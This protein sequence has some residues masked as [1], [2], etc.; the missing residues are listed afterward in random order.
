[1]SHAALLRVEAL[2]KRFGAL[3]V[4]D[5]ISLQLLPGEIH[6][7]IGP[8]GAGKSTLVAQISGQ[9]APDSGSIWLGEHNVTHW[10]VQRRAQQ[11]LGRTFQISSVFRSLSELDNVQVAFNA[12]RR[13]GSLWRR[14]GLQDSLGA[15]SAVLERLQVRPE[16]RAA[17]ALGYG[18][19]RQLELAMGLVQQPSVL[20]LDEPLAGL[21]AAE[22]Q[23]VVQ[24]L[25]ALRGKVAMLLIEHDMDAV[26]ALADRISVLV[27]GAVIA[28]GSPAEIRASAQVR[29]AYLGENA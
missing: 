15:A 9:L 3:T 14:F 11:G 22:A 7:L 17:A 19:V 26:F 12:Q 13:R 2:H 16:G 29:R 28:S 4:T 6:A 10:S 18:T 8:N 20:L 21:G 25:Q 24:Q 1:M 5:R 27:E 23:Q